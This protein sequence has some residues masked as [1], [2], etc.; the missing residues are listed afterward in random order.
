[1][2]IARKKHTDA[3]TAETQKKLDDS[4]AAWKSKSKTGIDKL[5]KSYKFYIAGLVLM[6]IWMGARML[7]KESVKN[8]IQTDQVFRVVYDTSR[9]NQLK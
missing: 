3:P 7:Q 1:M 9:N 5:N 2:L 4:L 6:V 8:S